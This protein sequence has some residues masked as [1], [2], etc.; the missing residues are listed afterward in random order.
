MNWIGRE[1]REGKVRPIPGNSPHDQLVSRWVSFAF[2]RICDDP[3]PATPFPQLQRTILRRSVCVY[4]AWRNLSGP[5]WFQSQ[6]QTLGRD[7]AA[8]RWSA[9]SPG[10]R[11]CRE[12]HAPSHRPQMSSGRLFLDR[13]AR[14]QSP[15]PLHRH[16]Q[17]NMHSQQAQAK[18]DISTLPERRHFYFALTCEKSRLT[19]SYTYSIFL[20]SSA[21]FM[22]FQLSDGLRCRAFSGIDKAGDP[23]WLRVVL[24]NVTR[25]GNMHS[26]FSGAL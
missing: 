16:P 3:L 6:N 25:V 15:S 22:G 1:W 18:D 19:C 14:Q 23:A 12:D 17:T 20:K 26:Q 10:S 11:T 21:S 2:W 9:P 5:M 7:R 13:V 4:K 24:Q 8:S